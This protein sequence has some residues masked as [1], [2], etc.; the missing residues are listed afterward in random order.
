[1]KEG[2]MPKQE[3]RPPLNIILW[4]K[5]A[6]EGRALLREHLKTAC[7]LTSVPDP[8]RIAAPPRELT[9]A[10]VLV[11]SSFAEAMA[12]A[13]QRLKL[14]HVTGAGIDAICLKTL[15]ASTT[16]ANAYFHGPAI[17][18][19]VMMMILALS[20]DLLNMDAKFRRGSWLGS[21]IWGA[22]PVPEIQGTTLGLIGY[23][24]IGKELVVRARA[25]GMKL[26][27]I[28]AHPPVHKPRH[29]DFYNGPSSLRELLKASDYLVLACP[30][31]EATRGLI[32]HREF[33]WMKR[34]ACLV[35]VAR[36]EVVQEEALY[37]ALKTRR[38]KGA[39]I[40]VWYRYPKEDHAFLPSHFP[41][42][43]LDNIIMT[44]HVSGWMKGT[45]DN[46]FKFIADNIDRLASGRQIQNVVQGPKRQRAVH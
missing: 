30:L 39:A 43:K 32:G 26:W 12:P 38:I 7:R 15:P 6:A 31:T 28:S 29:I 22:P 36:G 44:P 41:F 3:S 13:A 11:A 5:Q 17:S 16:I 18:E 42:H 9:R 45:R 33:S 35:N 24:H 21:W 40:D 37:H 20:R 23:G 4:G 10:D 27:V 8:S 14:L 2:R 25:F 46:R 1:M 34:T 19:Y